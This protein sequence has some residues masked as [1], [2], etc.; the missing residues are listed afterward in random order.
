MFKKI[1]ITT[2]FVPLLLLTS[3]N[4]KY[5]IDDLENNV[6][7]IEIS[8]NE[9]DKNNP[10][11]YLTVYYVLEKD[12]AQFKAACDKIS[13]L[14]FKK[15]DPCKCKGEHIVS[16]WYKDRV[17]SFDG[18][19]FSNYNISTKESDTNSW[20]CDRDKIKE[21]YEIAKEYGT[22]SEE[23]SFPKNNQ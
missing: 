19:Y 8:D 10:G 14:E 13:E 1:L 15:T 20:Q 17:D 7:K 21:I 22:K 2:L 6:E 11:E 4:K 5:T 23:S 16:L 3:C 18:F 12:N 9:T